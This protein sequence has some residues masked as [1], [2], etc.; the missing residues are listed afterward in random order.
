[1]FFA[2]TQEFFSFYPDSIKSSTLI[3]PVVL[4]DLK[5]NQHSISPKEDPVLEKLV[6]YSDTLKLTYNQNNLSLGYAALNY[7][8]PIKNL[9]V[10]LFKFFYFREITLY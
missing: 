3:P 1:M 8:Q 7:N 2:T 4:S 10:L 9:F 5:I 6:T